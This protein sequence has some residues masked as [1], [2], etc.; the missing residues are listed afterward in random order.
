MKSTH[1]TLHLRFLTILILFLIICENYH[2]RVS[3][4]LKIPS[5]KGE[6]IYEKLRKPTL[7]CFDMKFLITCF[8]PCGPGVGGGYQT[9]MDHPTLKQ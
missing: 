2:V 3:H 8:S 6:G 5:L 1:S 7:Q 9:Q 4:F